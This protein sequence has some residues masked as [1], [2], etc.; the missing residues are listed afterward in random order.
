MKK[1]ILITGGAGFLGN[2]LIQQL[3]SQEHFVR[4]YDSLSTQVHGKFESNLV[5]I[6]Q[7]NSNFEFIR[8]DVLDSSEMDRALEG[9][10]TVVHLAADTGTGQ[11]MYELQRYSNVNVTGT[12]TLLER[13]S[14]NR[15]PIKKIVLASSRAVYGEGKYSCPNHS[16]IFPDARQAINMAQGIY[17]PLCPKCQNT[18]ELLPTDEESR[19]NPNSIYGITKLAQEQMVMTFGKTYEIPT[20][21]LRYQNIYGPGQSLRNPYTGIL[22]IFSTRIRNKGRIE[23]FEDGLESRDFIFIDDVVGMTNIAILDDR[24][25][26]QSFNLGSGTST[27]VIEVIEKLEDRF[28]YQVEKHI[29]GNFRLGDIRHNVA[30]MSKYVRYFGRP[31]LTTFDAG[32]DCFVRWVQN[33]ENVIDNYEKSLSELKENRL[34]K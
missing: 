15:F 14:K 11:S 23:I 6:N 29:S 34:L 9:V 17:S 8:G 25:M 27:T 32:L 26:V 30:D 21:A 16:V 33:Q 24:E 2:A 10:D 20:I 28:E 22:S 7:S 13:I 19:M 18:L 31:N 4:A 3:L 12:A 1:N 5:S